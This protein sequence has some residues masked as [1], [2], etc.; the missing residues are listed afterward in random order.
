MSIG[1]SFFVFFFVSCKKSCKKGLTDFPYICAPKSRLAKDTKKHGKEKM[2]NKEKVKEQLKQAQTKERKK[3]TGTRET[4]K[5]NI[6]RNKKTGKYIVTLYLG[7]ELGKPKRSFQTCDTLKEAEALLKKHEYERANL[8]KRSTNTQI[9]IEEC[10]KA[11]IANKPLAPT[12]KEDYANI[13]RR[14]V[15]RGLGRKKIIRT[16]KIDIQ[17]YI[18]GLLREGEL[19]AKTINSDRTFLCSVFNYAKDCEYI[20]DNVVERVKRLPV[21][22][23]EGTAYTEGQIKELLTEIENSGDL[24]LKTFVYLGMCEGMRRGEISGLKWENIDFE[25]RRIHIIEVRTP[26]KGQVITKEPKTKKSRRTIAMTD[27]VKT[28][29]IEYRQ[30]QEESG[31]LGEYVIIGEKGLPLRPNQ[32]NNK[33][34]RFLEKHDLKHIRIHDLR[35]TFCTLGIDSGLDFAHMAKFLGHSNSRITEQIYTHLKDDSIDRVG[36]VMQNALSEIL[37]VRAEN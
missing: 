30:Q 21:D 22:E 24:R 2:K 15:S 12:T 18:D 29:L 7:A 31:L 17:E 19:K 35:H 1:L 16:K 14:I 25:N 10:A 8:G 3:G 11:Y 37:N 33:L 6:S 32:M 23:F 28:C 20:S 26:I 9:T 5:R 13:L 27:I 36:A 4:V 34:T